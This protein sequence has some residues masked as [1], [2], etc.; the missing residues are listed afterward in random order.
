MVKQKKMTHCPQKVT[1]EVSLKSSATVGPAKDKHLSCTYWPLAPSRCIHKSKLNTANLHVCIKE[2][3]D[4]LKI[5]DVQHKPAKHHVSIKSKEE[6]NYQK[7][8]QLVPH[9]AQNTL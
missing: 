3:V 6:G 5:S 2:N 4:I 1:A 9:L 8:I 7:S